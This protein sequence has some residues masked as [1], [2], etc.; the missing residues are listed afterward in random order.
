MEE[1]KNN[2]SYLKSYSLAVIIV[3]LLI[4]GY[5]AIATVN[6]TSNQSNLNDSEV[7]SNAYFTPPSSDNLN[8][9]H[10]GIIKKLNSNSVSSFK[11]Q[12]VDEDGKLVSY[13]TSSKIDLGLSEWLNVE[14]VGKRKVSTEFGYTIIE[15]ESIKLK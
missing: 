1:L 5:F 14:V 9:S 3:I 6:N 7:S 15:V 4:V 10:T 12:L 13:L 8:K 11:Y 2:K